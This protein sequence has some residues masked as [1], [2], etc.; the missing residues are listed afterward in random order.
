MGNRE[1]FV[2]GDGIGYESDTYGVDVDQN[3]IAGETE[4]T[5]KSVS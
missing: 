3:A 2:R 1:S 5:R 4:E